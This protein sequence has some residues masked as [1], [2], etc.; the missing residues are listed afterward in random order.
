[1]IKDITGGKL[2]EHSTVKEV[3]LSA[4]ELNDYYAGISCNDNY[5]KPQLILTTM[6]NTKRQLI[7]ITE[8]EVNIELKKLKNKAAGPDGIPTWYLK[9]AAEK[10]A[11]SLASF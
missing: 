2:K 8:A 5:I 11:Y 9:L 6:E 4:N 1:M 3:H 7:S 10:V